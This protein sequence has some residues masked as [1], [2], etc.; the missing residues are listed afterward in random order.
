MHWNP[1]HSFTEISSVEHDGSCFW[2]K[3]HRDGP[4]NKMQHLQKPWLQYLLP[5]PHSFCLLLLLLLACCI[6]LCCIAATWLKPSS[7]ALCF[8]LPA[9][10][11]PMCRDGLH[12]R[13]CTTRRPR[14]PPLIQQHANRMLVWSSVHV[15]DAKARLKEDRHE[16]ILISSSFPPELAAPVWS[17]LPVM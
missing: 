10:T 2:V 15:R 7:H 1:I 4:I 17:L 9:T 5:N 6:W 12:S 11:M 8:A 13:T 14:P 3:V 16:D